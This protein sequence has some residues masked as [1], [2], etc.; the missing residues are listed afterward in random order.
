MLG[1]THTFEVRTIDL[2][3]GGMGIVASANPRPGTV[4]S[5]RF[6]VPLGSRGQAMFESKARVVHSVFSSAESGFKVGLSFVE[7][8]PTSAAVAIQYL[9]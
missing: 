6:A 5:I 3:A 4:L 9:S 2:S 1:Q 8:P 7:L